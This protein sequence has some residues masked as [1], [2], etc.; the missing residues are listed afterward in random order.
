ME[1]NGSGTKRTSPRRRKRPT[2][3]QQRQ[4]LRAQE[5]TRQVQVSPRVGSGE[6]RSLASQD[7]LDSQ[8]TE[9]LY[10]FQWEAR[11]LD[12]KC[13]CC[14][15]DFPFRKICP[16]H[17][18]WPFDPS[19]FR[20]HSPK[21][22]GFLELKDQS[23]SE[24]SLKIPWKPNQM[25]PP[26]G[27]LN[28]SFTLWPLE[29]S[30]GAQ[31]PRE[32]NLYSQ[33]IYQCKDRLVTILPVSSSTYSKLELLFLNLVT[34]CVKSCALEEQIHLMYDANGIF[35]LTPPLSLRNISS[36]K[37]K[38]TMIRLWLVMGFQFRVVTSELKSKVFK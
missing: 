13:I 32:S 27:S 28:L 1:T 35:T 16:L 9:E 7:P 26:E 23:T 5:V 8:A 34:F 22:W 37:N 6:D 17:L 15:L 19:S 24:A 14:G 38:F 20:R 33:W 36:G 3:M 29:G 31:R 21:F 11:C 18:D 30:S 12:C 4:Q 25:K 10:V 2:C